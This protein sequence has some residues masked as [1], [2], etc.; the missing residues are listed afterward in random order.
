MGLK[1]ASLFFLPKSASL[2]VQR[3]GLFSFFVHKKRET[4]ERD[5][6]SRVGRA[7]LLLEFF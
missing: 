4:C 2:D 5:R 3:K 1:S 7:K 6:V